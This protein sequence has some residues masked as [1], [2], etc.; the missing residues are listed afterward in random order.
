VL[1]T[2]S[3]RRLIAS[4]DGTNVDYYDADVTS[5]T[6]YYPYGM[7]LRS[8]SDG[9][10]YR[11]GFQGQEMDDEVK[12][13]GNSVNYKYRMHDPRIGRFFAVDP[14]APKYPHYTPYSFSGNE[15]ISAVE[16]EGLEPNNVINS[17]TGV[18]TPDPIIRVD[19][20]SDAVRELAEGDRVTD[21]SGVD[22]RYHCGAVDPNGNVV[23]AGGYHAESYYNFALSYG[24]FYHAGDA[25]L[26]RKVPS[27]FINSGSQFIMWNSGYANLDPNSALGPEL[28]DIASQTRQ[29]WGSNQALQDL[30]PAVID[31][32]LMLTGVYAIGKYGVTFIA[33]RLIQKGLQKGVTIAAGDM[34]LSE[35]A[36]KAV[37][38]MAGYATPTITDGVAKLSIS[39]S[40]S[41]TPAN[42][43]LVSSELKA[44]GATSFRV[45]SGPT[46]DGLRAVL[47]HRM[48]TGR[49]YKG[50]DIAPGYMPGQFILTKTL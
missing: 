24:P 38:E 21:E 16:L 44:L 40:A 13:E 47:R 18:S 22:A 28:L 46:K 17:E 33:S 20:N 35:A 45:M 7:T 9:G 10:N 1:A 50:F 5:T 27:Y 4:T 30:T 25:Q 11:Y 15:V 49:G 34:V 26:S 2:A 32:I 12:G 42:I 37:F 3:D 39:Y 8:E 23:G 41:L 6:E 31:G 36:N 48:S 19:H 29:I 43:A 14:L